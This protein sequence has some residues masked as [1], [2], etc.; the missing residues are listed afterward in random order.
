MSSSNSNPQ[1]LNAVIGLNGSAP[2]CFPIIFL[3]IFLLLL[4]EDGNYDI[5]LT[6]KDTDARREPN[7]TK[8]VQVGKWQQNPELNTL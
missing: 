6:N 5:H 7:V 2:Q 3:L 4:W 8:K 1:C